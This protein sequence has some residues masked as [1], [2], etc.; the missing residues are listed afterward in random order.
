M[1]FVMMIT[2]LTLLSTV[3]GKD[4][5]DC[6]QCYKTPESTC[7]GKVCTIDVPMWDSITTPCWGGFVYIGP[8]VFEAR[9][10]GLGFALKGT[11][12]SF[13]PAG[14][15]NPVVN[16]D[17]D[18][19]VGLRISTGLITPHDGWKLSTTWQRLY[20]R[21]KRSINVSFPNGLFP[22][23]LHPASFDGDDTP[24]A[25][26]AKA[27]WNLRYNRLD[28]EL[29]RPFSVSRWF[30]LRPHAGMR[31]AWVH[32]SYDVTYSDLL[33]DIPEAFA[34]KVDMH[35]NFWGIGILAG[36]DA[37]WKL[38]ERWSLVTD[39]D[40]SFLYGY[41]KIKQKQTRFTSDGLGTRVFRVPDFYHISR[42]I[43][44]LLIGVQY[45]RPFWDDKYEI[46]VKAGWELQILNSQNQF[47]RFV[48]D[49]TPGL[50]V[51]NQGDLTIQGVSLLVRIDY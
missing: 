17:F 12:T 29:E 8:V 10:N 33:D 50:F 41:F 40:T 31:S 27:E 19:S 46:T 18:W 1:K 9:E 38:C 2:I 6:E 24:I 34:R 37:I 20:T 49:T 48:D 39:L 7:P 21:D 28:L 13:M 45:M 47:L 3:Q 26:S 51:A 25:Q 44:D 4:S 36:L 14:G 30:T 5:L 43:T 22:V 42:V 15:N 16:L 32:Q 35:C 23:F 11:D